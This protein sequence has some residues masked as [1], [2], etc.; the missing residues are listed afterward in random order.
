MTASDEDLGRLFRGLT[1]LLAAAAA[2]D[3]SA[4]DVMTSLR[5]IALSEN[6]TGLFDLGLIFRRERDLFDR[7]R[8]GDLPFED[9]HTLYA[10]LLDPKLTASALSHSW[11]TAG[12]QFEVE[13]DFDLPLADMLADLKVDAGRLREHHEKIMRLPKDPHGTARLTLAL[14]QNT[15]MRSISDALAELAGHGMRSAGLPELLALFR[16]QGLNL[17]RQAILAPRTSMLLY[18]TTFVPLLV[19]AGMSDAPRVLRPFAV[20][21]P[22]TS[23][24]L[25]LATKEKE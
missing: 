3:R 16:Q 21:A 17:P 10:E 11:L 5:E 9:A 25:I 24:V 4:G 20:S 13:V 8:R 2:D 12:E 6:K 14:M 15:R 18:Q 22:I 23:N 1:D 7:V 19:A